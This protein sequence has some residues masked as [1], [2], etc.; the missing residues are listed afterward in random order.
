MVAGGGNA[1][2]LTIE[3]IVT[4]I[5]DALDRDDANAACDV[6]DSVWDCDKGGGYGFIMR[7]DGT[8][9]PSRGLVVGT[10]HFRNL[11]RD[12]AGLVVAAYAEGKQRVQR[13]IRTAAGL[14]A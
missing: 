4:R 12:I 6:L 10:V 1:E 8:S 3:E 9:M 11:R 14:T 2:S 13:E 5:A 7:L